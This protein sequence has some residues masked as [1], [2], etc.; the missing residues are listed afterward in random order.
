MIHISL[1]KPVA[2]HLREKAQT[3]GSK[4][5]FVDA[6]TS[7]TYGDLEQR[8]A[9]LAT[10]LQEMGIKPGDRVAIHFPSSVPWIEVLPGHSAPGCGGRAHKL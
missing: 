2:E 3:Q 8:T 9:R 5:A 1:I 4:T 7:V 10:A 6:Q